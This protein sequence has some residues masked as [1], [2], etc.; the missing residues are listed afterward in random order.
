MARKKKKK[1]E[2]LGSVEDTF[3]SNL[4]FTL[5][6]LDAAG[7][8]K[9]DAGSL[10]FSIDGS[11]GAED[12]KVAGNAGQVSSAKPVSRVKHVKHVKPV[13][14]A[15]QKKFEDLPDLPPLKFIKPE[16]IVHEVIHE[17]DYPPEAGVGKITEIT[18]TVRIV[19]DAANRAIREKRSLKLTPLMEEALSAASQLRAKVQSAGAVPSSSKPSVAS[20][21]VSVPVQRKPVSHGAPVQRQSA[22]PKPKKQ[23]VVRE[24]VRPSPVKKPSPRAAPVVT[25]EEERPIPQKKIKSA[26]T[27]EILEPLRPIEKTTT[28]EARPAMAPTATK[29]FSSDTG[30]PGIVSRVPK[31]SMVSTSMPTDSTPAQVEDRKKVPGEDK[32]LPG[33][34]RICGRCGGHR[35]KE[36]DDK[37][38]PLSYV[39]PYLYA[40]KYVCMDCGHEFGKKE[41][42]PTGAGRPRAT[43]PVSAHAVETPAR[44]EPR[45]ISTSFAGKPQQISSASAASSPP[46]QSSPGVMK[47]ESK[48][49]DVGEGVR[50]ESLTEAFKSKAFVRPSE[51]ARRE[52]TARKQEF[53]IPSEEISQET[54]AKPEGGRLVCPKCGS[55]SFNVIEDKSRPISYGVGSGL[56]IIYAKIHQ[57]RKCG[58][59]IE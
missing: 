55:T 52:G 10:T 46:Q 11:G 22:R 51:I 37:S 53:N 27:E 48:W 12:S 36:V 50:V 42:E 15:P 54:P 19:G 25:S 35:F 31:A 38:R 9:A 39:P 8:K 5:P 29:A 2:D 34:R 58:Y 24:K 43:A 59:K 30:Q 17:F 14:E 18:W 6:D 44:E 32:I 56:G 41:A 3:M 4:T 7:S 49:E 13:Q 21:G 28:T 1:L 47:L 20:A 57:C 33:G 45:Q 16:D 23:P 40:K 26:L